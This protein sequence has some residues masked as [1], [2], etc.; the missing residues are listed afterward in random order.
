MADLSPMGTV[1]KSVATWLYSPRKAPRARALAPARPKAGRGQPS[2]IFIFWIFGEG[3]ALANLGCQRGQPSPFA[4]QPDS[5][6]GS[7][8]KSLLDLSVGRATGD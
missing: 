4:S 6:E 1:G 5:H 7:L 8:T 2:Q 3:K